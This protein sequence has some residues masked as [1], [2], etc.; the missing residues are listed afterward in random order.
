MTLGEALKCLSPA[1]KLLVSKG[2]EV[3]TLRRGLIGQPF[4]SKCD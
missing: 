3:Q 2:D 4:V 1:S